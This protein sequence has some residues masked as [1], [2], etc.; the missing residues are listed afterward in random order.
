MQL[1]IDHEFKSLIRPLTTEERHYLEE[2]I[3]KEGCRDSLIIWNG[4]LIDGHNRFEICQ[5]HGIEFNTKE[6]SLKDRGE[7]KEW[8]IRNQ[9]SRRNLSPYDRSQLALVLEDVIRAKAKE[10]QRE[11]HGN[12]HT[13]AIP[14]NSAEVQNPMETRSELAKIAGVSRDTIDRV[15]VI[16]KEATP[17]QK[18]RLSS[19]AATVNKVYREIR[20]LVK[21]DKPIKPTPDKQKIEETEVKENPPVQE[22]EESGPVKIRPHKNEIDEKTGF[23]TSE[24]LGFKPAKQQPFAKSIISNISCAVQSFVTN[25]NAFNSETILQ[26]LTADEV[27][28]INSC[29]NEAQY[30]LKNMQENLV[31]IYK[32]R[33]KQ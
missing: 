1:Q 17:D 32:V 23:Q 2:N 25:L 31:K 33:K 5:K 8:I 11:F 27:I 28:E 19:G 4:I 9:F 20:P 13:G 6:I 21:E 16:E 10:R 26:K 18:E 15:R 3:I 30:G 24:A 22:V 7:V 14:Q 12:Q 29:L